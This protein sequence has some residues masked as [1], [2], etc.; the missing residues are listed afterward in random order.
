MMVIDTSA[1]AD[2]RPIALITQNSYPQVSDI[3]Y[4]LQ[5]NNILADLTGYAGSFQCR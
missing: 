2:M 5:L 3:I 4:Q 1:R